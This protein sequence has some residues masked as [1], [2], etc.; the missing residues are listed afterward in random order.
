MTPATIL[1]V[2][3]F[4]GLLAWSLRRA[5]ARR[6]LLARNNLMWFLDGAGLFIQ[7]WM[8]PALQ[9]VLAFSVLV[10]VVPSLRGALPVPAW[11][12]LVLNLVVV[13]YLYYW[14][15]RLLHRKRFWPAHVVHHSATHLDVFVTSRNTLWSSLCIVY[16]YANALLMVVLPDARGV[17][18]GV[19][20][21]GALDL[22]KHSSVQPPAWLARVLG[23]VLVLPNDH[24]LHHGREEVHANYG[25]VFNLWDRVHGTWRASPQPPGELGVPMTMAG[26]KQLVWPLP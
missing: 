6:A 23:T 19:A 3:W 8:V 7:G 18:L 24:A 17:A 14:N 22:W 25:A 10:P 12:G 15:H 13:D 16:A 20:I 26:W 5:E 2:L 1:L 11:V 9:A 4:W 21:T